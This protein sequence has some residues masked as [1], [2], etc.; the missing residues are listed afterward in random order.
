MNLAIL[1][2]FYK[3]ADICVNRLQLL[4]QYNPQLKI[5]GL[6]GGDP[7]DADQYQQKLKIYLDDFY[8][9]DAITDSVWKWEHGDLMILDWFEKRGNNLIWDSVAVVQW[10]MLVFDS[11]KSQ[12]PDLQKDQIF[13]SGLQNLDSETEKNWYWT[14]PEHDQRKRYTDF[15]E[16]VKTEYRFTN[17]LLCCLFI[18]QI[19]PRLFFKKYLSVKEKEL[20]MLEYKIP[21][22]ASIFQLSFYEKEMGVRWHEKKMKPLNAIPEEIP[23]DYIQKELRKKK[24]WRIFH[25]YFK[26][27]KDE[28]TVNDSWFQ[29]L[30]RL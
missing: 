12:F 17:E 13:L 15:L 22:Y 19:F 26:I 7:A 2:W 16:Y 28:K 9:F 1:F 27:W 23:A 30:F 4:K 5:Y 20:G 3:E 25:P 24:G 11:L 6:Y 29:K 21:I 8:V 14:S 10:D 18:F